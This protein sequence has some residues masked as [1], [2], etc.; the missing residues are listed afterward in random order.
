MM[1]QNKA[2]CPHKTLIKLDKSTHKTKLNDGVLPVNNGDL[3]CI[4]GYSTGNN[5]GFVGLMKQ[6]L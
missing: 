4:T 1:P 2:I 6:V 5:T 3:P